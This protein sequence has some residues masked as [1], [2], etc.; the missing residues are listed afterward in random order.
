MS[1]SRINFFKHLA[2]TS[3]EPLA[4]EIVNAEGMYLIDS[5][6]KKYMD[7]IAGIGVSALGHKHSAIVKAI[8]SQA[9]KF[10]HT[11]VYG[12]FI[13]SPQVELA[14][15][16]TEIL[17]KKLNS[18]YLVN[19]GTEAIEGA[20]KLAKRYTGRNKFVAARK[21]YHGS[22]QGAMSLIS[23]A[24]F[25]DAFSPML[26]NISFIDFNS[27]ED[28]AKIDEDTAA[29]IFET[30]KAEEGIYLPENNYLR[31]VQE[32]CK[33]VGALFIL[34]EIQAG[35]G[36]T[37]KMF[38]FEHFD[39]V[40]DILC[41]AKAFGGGM[42]IGAFIADKEIMKSLTHDPVLGHITTYGGNPVCAAAALAAL[43]SILE[44]PYLNEVDA[45]NK[46]ICSILDREGLEYRQI[47]LWFAVE[48]GSFENVLSI[49]KKGLEQ[50]ILVDWFLFNQ[51]C[52]RIAPP[53]VISMAE[54]EE[55]I[56]ALARII[57]D[58]SY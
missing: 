1:F 34:D 58:H 7:L 20:M 15:Q 17:P 51:N 2:Q 39:I 10:I 18:V 19:S 4:L 13:L 14:R 12:E 47:G 45:K 24:W 52:I 28:L 21:A 16:L 57:R 36:R 22:T 9:E 41:L 31:K 33:Q 46:L 49:V 44:G 32:R 35:Y 3:P 53:L 26:P 29:V 6:G 50:G 11:M 37:G 38:A 42:P 30:I 56:G 8:Q 40:P 54:I 48:A 5:E 23:E 43:R 25:V 55:G 27:S